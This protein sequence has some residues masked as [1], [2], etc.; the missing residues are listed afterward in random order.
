VDD[1][2]G[3]DVVKALQNLS[4][5]AFQ[6]RLG[7]R[8]LG[9]ADACDFV[10]GEF[11]DEVLHELIGDLDDWLVADFVKM[12]YVSVAR[13]LLQQEAFAQKEFGCR[14]LELAHSHRVVHLI[15]FAV[16]LLLR[17]RHFSEPL[18]I[19]W[20]HFVVQ[21][22]G[23]VDLAVSPGLNFVNSAELPL[24]YFM[25][26]LVLAIE[27]LRRDLRHA[28]WVGCPAA[29]RGRPEWRSPDF[30]SAQ[31]NRGRIKRLIA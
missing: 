22:F 27:V 1:S 26:H 6:M 12:N 31:G 14:G 8:D 18:F 20:V 24:S 11:K 29:H 21:F 4:D 23:C 25:E 5:D 28:L 3:V 19:L 30:V 9:L 10:L 17:Q 13:Q 7:V 15:N 16:P 2:V